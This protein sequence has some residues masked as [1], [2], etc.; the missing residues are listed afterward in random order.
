[1]KESLNRE[2]N[3]RKERDGKVKKLLDDPIKF[4]LTNNQIKAIM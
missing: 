4:P 2:E 1:M 3:R